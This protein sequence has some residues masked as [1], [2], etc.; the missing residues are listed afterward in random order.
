MPA[1]RLNLQPADLLEQLSLLGLPLFLV[2]S[3]LP[4]REELAGAVQELTLPLAHLDQDGLRD[5]RR[6]PGSSCGH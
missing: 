6:S 5:Q 2:P 4:S 3:L 1:K